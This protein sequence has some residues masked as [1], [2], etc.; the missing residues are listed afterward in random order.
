M[1][2]NGTSRTRWLRF[3]CVAESMSGICFTFPAGVGRVCKSMP[4]IIRGALYTISENS[5]SSSH[6]N[7]LE[8]ICD[9]ERND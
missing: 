8:L 3:V 5:L 7:E 4:L 1:L 9:C 2:C 6:L